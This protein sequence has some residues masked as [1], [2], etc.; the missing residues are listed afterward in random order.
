[1]AKLID[2]NNPNSS[3]SYLCQV[4]AEAVLSKTK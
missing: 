4:G 2:K 1:V 3:E